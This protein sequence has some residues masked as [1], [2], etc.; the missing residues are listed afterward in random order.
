MTHRIP[1][2]RTSGGNSIADFD[3]LA[4]KVDCEAEGENIIEWTV[5]GFAPS[6]ALAQSRAERAALA[7]NRPD[8]VDAR[9]AALMVAAQEGRAYIVVDGERDSLTLLSMLR[10][11]H[12][13]KK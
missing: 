12:A 11:L 13:E 7:V 4:L 3:G 10:K 1:W 8:I 9:I 2:A 6:R 5:T